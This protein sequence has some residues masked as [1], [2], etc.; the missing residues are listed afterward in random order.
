M[1]SGMIIDDYWSITDIVSMLSTFY[2]SDLIQDR[3]RRM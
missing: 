1:I 3:F 2:E